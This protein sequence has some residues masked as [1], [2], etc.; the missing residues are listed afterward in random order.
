MTTE[1]E[2]ITEYLKHADNLFNDVRKHFP[3]TSHRLVQNINIDKILFDNIKSAVDAY[4][5]KILKVSDISVGN[6]FLYKVLDKN[7]NK[8]GN[9]TENGAIIAKKEMTSEA[10][11]L[12]KAIVEFVEAHS[13]GEIFELSQ[14]PGNIRI[15]EKKRLEAM[16]VSGHPYA[17]WKYHSDA[18]AGEPID[19]VVFNM[20]IYYGGEFMNIEVGDTR[21]ESDFNCLRKFPSY[22][23]AGKTIKVQGPSP[24][25]LKTGMCAIMDPRTIHRTLFDHLP[26][27]RVSVDFRFRIKKPELLE[28]ILKKA[29]IGSAHKGYLNYDV[30]KKVGTTKQLVFNETYK[31][32]V[33]KNT[34]K[35][36]DGK[37]R[38]K[39]EFAPKIRDTSLAKTSL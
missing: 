7:I 31:E 19:S 34:K 25:K 10:N 6:N 11:N 27:L 28:S 30:W 20:P 4:I 16:R 1:K 29:Y 8:I 2:A 15:S 3:G 23:E 32:Y 36:R 18:W 21:P 26:V 38:F 14:C 12:Q 35:G 9:L 33:N 22:D 24:I 13:A 5:E 17:S 39:D 37:H